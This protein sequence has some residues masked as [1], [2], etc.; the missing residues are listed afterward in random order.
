MERVA[1]ARRTA[2]QFPHELSGGL[3]QRVGIATALAL[4]P[5]LIVA[6]EP[7]SALDVSVQGQII[8]LLADLQRASGLAYVFISHDLGVVQGVSDRVAVMYLGRIVEEGP[9]E[10]V[11]GSPQ[12]PYTRALLSAIPPADPEVEHEPIRLEGEI[13][14]PIDPPSGCTFHPR[15]PLAEAICSDVAPPLYDFGGT[16]VAAC[17]VT[18]R[19][20]REEHHARH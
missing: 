19:A 18:A 13:P 5:K 17:H 12:H 7:V 3:R 4:E 14:T 1:L 8:E 16:Q 20:V 2:R 6:D 15:C 11:Y 9:V 10:R